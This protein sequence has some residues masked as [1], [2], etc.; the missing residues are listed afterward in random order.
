VE[1]VTP[2]LPADY[3]NQLYADSDDPWQISSGWYEH[4]K[5]AVLLA[6]LPHQ[7]YPLVFEPGC[8]NGE[9][10]AQLAARC[11]RLIAWDVADAAI[12]RARTLTA[13]LTGVEIRHA[14]LPA[15][16]PEEHADLIVFAE[17]GYYLDASDLDQ[18]IDHALDRLNPGGVLLALHWRHPAHD[19]PLTGDQVH[20]QINAQDRL[21]QLGSYHDPDFLLDMWAHGPMPSVGQQTGLL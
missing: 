1:V 18:A 16:W 2:S 20:D 17:V 7:H 19:Y 13:Q 15:Q 6:C 11:D 10:T 21:H 4:R 12:E 14:G 5:R 3:F 9:L 8:S